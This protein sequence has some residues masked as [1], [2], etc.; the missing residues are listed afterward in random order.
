MKLIH[1]PPLI[2]YTAWV[3][4]GVVSTVEIVAETDKSYW[5]YDL[6]NGYVPKSSYVPMFDTIVD[7]RFHIILHHKRE[8]ENLRNKVNAKYD[9]ILSLISHLHDKGRTK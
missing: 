7:A 5:M 4:S 9:H 3:H 8:L 2:K 1:N 6:S